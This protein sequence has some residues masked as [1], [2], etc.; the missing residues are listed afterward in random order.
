MQIKT[1]LLALATLVSA[2]AGIAVPAS[3]W[4]LVG[5]REAS[6]TIDRDVVPVTGAERHRQ[7]RLCVKKNA[8]NFKDLDVVFANGGKQD[9]KVRNRIPAGGCTRAIDLVGQ[10]RNIQSI[11]VLYDTVGWIGPNAVVEFYAR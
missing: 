2:T 5:K 6:K 7:I 9:V 1:S 4:E 8:V 11:V 10:K 3:A